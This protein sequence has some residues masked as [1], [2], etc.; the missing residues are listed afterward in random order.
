[1]VFD[2]LVIQSNK[3]RV[4]INVKVKWVYEH[5]LI[6]NLV[7]ERNIYIYMYPNQNV[8]CPAVGEWGNDSKSGFLK[9]HPPNMVFH[10]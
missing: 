5:N 6:G 4:G 8:P 10:G 3:D 7:S 9:N 2:I 1:M